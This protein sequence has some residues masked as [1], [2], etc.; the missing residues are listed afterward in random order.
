MGSWGNR[1]TVTD[2]EDIGNVVAAVLFADPAVNN[3]IVYT[4]GETIT[5]GR[6]AELV[7]E[8]HQSQEGRS[9]VEREV[10]AVPALQEMLNP[11]G[12]LA[13]GR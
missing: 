10:I 5:Y 8:E 13:T 7:E 9:E 1:V 12:I 3:H 4:T 2:V 6:L 11:A